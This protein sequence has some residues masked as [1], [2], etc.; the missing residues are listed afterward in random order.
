MMTQT[1]GTGPQESQSCARKLQDIL[2]LKTSEQQRGINSEHIHYI[3][4]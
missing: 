1:L 3:L 4:W 2:E